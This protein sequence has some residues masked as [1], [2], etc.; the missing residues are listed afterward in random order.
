MEL[1]LPPISVSFSNVADDVAMWAF[2]GGKLE[3]YNVEI[4]ALA[5]ANK[6][7]TTFHMRRREDVEAGKRPY[8]S[9]SNDFPL[10]DGKFGVKAKHKSPV[11]INGGRPCLQQKS[12]A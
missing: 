7:L 12:A 3:Q 8:D 10:V 1:K 4:A 11:A 9:H 2:P 6:I 5:R